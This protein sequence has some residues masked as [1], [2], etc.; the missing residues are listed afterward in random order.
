MTNLKKIIIDEAGVKID[1]MIEVIS[2][3]TLLYSSGEELITKCVKEKSAN[4]RLLSVAL[5]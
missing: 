3:G 2:S 1:S 4:R 5:L